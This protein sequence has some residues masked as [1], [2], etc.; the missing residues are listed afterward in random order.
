[1]NF[2]GNSTVIKCKTQI[3]IM[4]AEIIFKM[5]IKKIELCQKLKVLKYI[6]LL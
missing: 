6:E 2:V 5:I 3:L 4:T 1:M